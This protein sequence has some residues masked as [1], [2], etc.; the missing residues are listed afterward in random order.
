MRATRRAA[1]MAKAVQPNF[2]RA[3]SMLTYGNSKLR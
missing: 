2:A 1:Y 3:A